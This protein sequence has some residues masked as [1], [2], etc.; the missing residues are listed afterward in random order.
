MNP[1]LIFNEIQQLSYDELINNY[2]YYC[3][4]CQLIFDRGNKNDKQIAGKIINYLQITT[5]KGRNVKI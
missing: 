2:N 4:Y 5:G 3:S 1:E